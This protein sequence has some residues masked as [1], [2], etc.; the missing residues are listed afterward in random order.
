MRVTWFQSLVGDQAPHARE[1]LSLHSTTWES[2]PTLEP[3]L[4]NKEAGHCS[5]SSLKH[6]NKEPG[7]QRLK[8]YFSQKKSYEIYLTC[9][10]CTFFPYLFLYPVIRDRYECWSFSSYTMRMRSV[11]KDNEKTKGS[12]SPWW[13]KK[14]IIPTPATF[15]LTS[16][17]KEK[18]KFY[19][20]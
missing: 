12:S 14:F 17:R 5:Q 19:H 15:L 20:V 7:T 10:L 2:P 3:V 9:S 8:T 11:P 4:C 16:F 18:L 1:Q 13:L 6:Q